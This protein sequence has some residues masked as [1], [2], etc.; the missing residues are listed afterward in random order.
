MNEDWNI[1]YYQSPTQIISPVQEFIEGLEKR[2]Q[3]KI[4]RTLELL[5]DFSISI[6]PPY[7]KKLECFSF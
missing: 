6:G 3:N 4:V 7:A 2:A 1:V 5:E